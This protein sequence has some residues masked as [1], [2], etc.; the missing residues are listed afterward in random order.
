MKANRTTSDR[1][2][3][4][5]G[6]IS[7]LS[8]A[9]R[10]S[11]AGLPVTVLEASRLGFGASTRNQGWLHAGAW[12][13]AGHPELARLCRE[14]AEQTIEFCPDCL[15]PDHAGMAYLFSGSDSE[16]T[17]WTEAWREA[18]IDFVA[19]PVAELR[20]RI[21]SLKP[22]AVSRAFR[23]PD[24]VFRPHV[25][26]SHMA[27][28]AAACGVEIRCE[29]PVTKLLIEADQ[30]V[31]VQSGSRERI[32]ARVVIL[33]GNASGAMLW[34]TDDRAVSPAQSDYTRVCL[35]TS[36]LSVEPGV[37]RLPFCLVDAEGMNH[38][39]HGRTSV[40]GSNRWKVVADPSDQRVDTPEVDKLKARMRDLFPG[41]DWQQ[42]S[43][44]AWSGTTMQAMHVEQITPGDCPLPTV[45]DH[46][47]ELPVV[48]NL[49]SVFPGRATLWPYLAEKTCS[50]V[51]NNF[52]DRNNL[53]TAKP[54]WAC[55]VS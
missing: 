46:A 27:R 31:G 22:E 19:W 17:R 29:T 35:K 23:L 34:P 16:V 1:I 10:L 4:V 6:G 42:C 52:G 7:G 48:H 39:P 54:P 55:N 9:C 49:F 15:E 12:F 11:Q 28:C 38:L 30:A 33:A 32:A 44:H 36:L 3:I 2:V 43:T 14:S 37:S 41:L 25:L 24:R 51:L 45:I 50:A 53:R 18:E 5:G 13:A 47:W 8:I 40:F 21:P 20:S 26:L